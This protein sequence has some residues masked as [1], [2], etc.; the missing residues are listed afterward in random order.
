MIDTPHNDQIIG[1]TLG[2]FFLC[3]G[4]SDFLQGNGG[5]DTY[6][7]DDTCKTATIDNFDEAG[8]YDLILLEC[9]SSNI[10]LLQSSEDLVIV[11]S[12]GQGKAFRI[13]LKQWFNST[14]YQRIIIKTLDKI[15]AFLPVSITELQANDGRLFPIQIE[16]DEDC[17]GEHR[18]IDLSQ[19]EFTKCVRDW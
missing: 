6:K 4:G 10:N 14:Q 17:E 3:S 11:C 13:Y 19:L 15:T 12:L 5:K 9:P 2:N 8:N 1:N 16:K 18:E 7:I